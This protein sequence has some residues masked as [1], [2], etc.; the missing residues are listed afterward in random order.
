LRLRGRGL[1]DAGHASSAGDQIIELEVQA[2]VPRD[3]RQREAY[4][5]I[6]EGF[7]GDWRR[8]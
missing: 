3:A 1:P 6:R 5:Q 4:A 2:P 7:A 8:E